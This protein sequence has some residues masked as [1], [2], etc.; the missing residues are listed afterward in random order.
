[1]DKIILELSR[2]DAKRL[3]ITLAEHLNCN[4]KM[5]EENSSDEDRQA[6]LDAF[7]DSFKNS[8][9]FCQK[10]INELYGKIYK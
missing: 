1:M 6:F 5:M 2:E 7:R 10:I 3:F 8:A 4:L 9:D